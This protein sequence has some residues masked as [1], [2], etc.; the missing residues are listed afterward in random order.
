MSLSSSTCLW[1]YC[2][3]GLLARFYVAHTKTR[4][5]FDP[6][7]KEKRQRPSE[8]NSRVK[9]WME[10]R[11]VSCGGGECTL[12]ETAGDGG[13]RAHHFLNERQFVSL[14]FL[15]SWH[16]K[17]SVMHSRRPFFFPTCIH[18][19]KMTVSPQFCHRSEKKDSNLMFV[20]F[21]RDSIYVNR[22]RLESTRHERFSWSCRLRGRRCHSRDKF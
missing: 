17:K 6:K 18:K 7:K 22:N 21:E 16:F 2:S 20:I 14:I 15:F 5:S 12:K 3:H 4:F 19:N 9:E 11:F 13:V 1:V 10:L 8:H